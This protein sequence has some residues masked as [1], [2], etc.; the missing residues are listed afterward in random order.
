MFAYIP[1]IL[2]DIAVFAA[3]KRVFLPKAETGHWIRSWMYLT[4]SFDANLNPLIMEVG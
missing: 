4:A 1:I 3:F 2:E